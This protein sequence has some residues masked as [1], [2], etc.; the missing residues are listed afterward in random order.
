MQ[1]VNRRLPS[2]NACPT[3]TLD[4]AVTRE[5]RR[6]R[7]VTGVRKGAMVRGERGGRDGDERRDSR[8]G[9]ERRDSRHGDERRDREGTGVRKGAMVNGERGGRED[10][11]GKGAM[12][13]GERGGRDGDEKRDWRHHEGHAREPSSDYARE[14]P[15]SFRSVSALW[16]CRSIEG[17]N[18]RGCGSSRRIVSGGAPPVLF[19]TNNFRWKGARKVEEEES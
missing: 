4:D 1:D 15:S 9:D 6:D 12:V 5:E 11:D 19:A 10:G 16:S 7:E 13:R 3:H 8:R 17:L 14:P 18:G 2:S